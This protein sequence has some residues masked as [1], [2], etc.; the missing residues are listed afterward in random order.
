M[1]F[2]LHFFFLPTIYKPLRELH[3]IS[4]E[5]FRGINVQATPAAG[6]KGGVLGLTHPRAEGGHQAVCDYVRQSV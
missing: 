2:Q 5:R 4:A 3:F 1:L 6:E